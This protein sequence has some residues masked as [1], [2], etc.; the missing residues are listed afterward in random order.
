MKAARSANVVDLADL[1]YSA[2]V[3]YLRCRKCLCW[4]IV[5]KGEDGPATR[6]VFGDPNSAENNM[7]ARSLVCR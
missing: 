6:I 2:R 4:W 1:L 5:P 7:Q 3:D